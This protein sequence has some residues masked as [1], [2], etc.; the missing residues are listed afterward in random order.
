MIKVTS[1]VKCYTH[2]DDPGNDDYIDM[3]VENLDRDTSQ[4]WAK[5]TLAG[6]TYQ[7]DV[8]DLQD[9]CRNVTNGGAR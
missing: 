5:I 2:P 4:C 9:A 7:V 3:V 6:T 1:V 8:R